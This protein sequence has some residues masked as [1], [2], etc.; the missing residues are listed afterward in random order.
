MFSRG[1]A[2]RFL[3]RR[4]GVAPALLALA[5]LF[6][7][8]LLHAQD[9]EKPEKTPRKLIYKVDPEYPLELKRAHIGGMV[10]LDVLV[11][12]KGT[13]HTISVVGGN[14][15]FV[16]TTVRAVRRWKWAPAESATVVRFNAGFDANH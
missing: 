2:I 7:P 1:P 12:S 15:V 10:R 8:S 16:E 13:A 9:T 14:P 6:I 3:S 5:C 4:A 11:N